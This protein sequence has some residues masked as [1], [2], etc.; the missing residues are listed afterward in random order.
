MLTIAHRLNTI[1]DYDRVIVLDKGRLMQFDTPY[2]LIQQGNGIFYELFQNLSSDIR[3][4]L[5][6]MAQIAHYRNNEKNNS[7][8]QSLIPENNYEFID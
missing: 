7:T 4:E 2:Q 3:N 6:R 5:K 8:D 1:I